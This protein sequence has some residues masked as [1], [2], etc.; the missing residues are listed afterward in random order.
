[1]QM[2]MAI[3]FAV[4]YFVILTGRVRKKRVRTEA[5]LAARGRFLR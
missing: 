5:E 3:P 2:K 4:L 1:M